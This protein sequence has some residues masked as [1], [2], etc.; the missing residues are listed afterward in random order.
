MH[1]HDTAQLC[2]SFC[3]VSSFIDFYCTAHTRLYTAYSS[4]ALQHAVVLINVLYHT[5]RSPIVAVVCPI[6]FMHLTALS[7]TNCLLLIYSK[8]YHHA[9]GV[10]TY[11][12]CMNLIAL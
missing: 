4:G 8:Y 1:I 3:C 11:V 9:T 2:K 10:H 5:M 6:E 12:L 7:T